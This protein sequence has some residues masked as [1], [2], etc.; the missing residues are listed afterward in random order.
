M[1]Y[2]DAIKKAAEVKPVA[3]KPA[4]EPVSKKAA[5]PSPVAPV[6]APKVEKKKA[7]KKA[8]VEEEAAPKVVEEPVSLPLDIGVAASPWTAMARKPATAKPAPVPEKVEK[9]KAESEDRTAEKTEKVE[10]GAV[11]SKTDDS[12][13]KA[14]KPRREAGERS[15]KKTEKK[16]DKKTEEKPAAVEPVV[17]EVSKPLEIATVAAAGAWGKATIVSVIAAKKAEVVVAPTPAPKKSRKGAAQKE[18][19]PVAATEVAPT[20]KAAPVVEESAP[21]AA[22]TPIEETKSSEI[23][24]D[25]SLEIEGATEVVEIDVEARALPQ[26]PLSEADAPIAVL[27]PLHKDGDARAETPVAP[28]VPVAVSPVKL[29]TEQDQQLQKGTTVSLPVG[30]QKFV[31]PAGTFTFIGTLPAEPVAAPVEPVRAAPVRAA[32]APVSST[33]AHH[34]TAAPHY[35]THNNTMNTYHNN[36]V[37]AN[38][39]NNAPQHQPAGANAGGGYQRNGTMYFDAEPRPYNNSSYNSNT[40]TPS[41]YQGHN[42]VS[43]IGRGGY[44]GGYHSDVPRPNYEGGGGR[45]GG[46]EGRGGYTPVYRGGGGVPRYENSGY[47]PPV[48]NNYSAPVSHHNSHHDVGHHPHQYS[49]APAGGYGGSRYNNMAPPAHSNAYRGGGTSYP[50]PSSNSYT[51]GMGRGRGNS[52]PSAITSPGLFTGQQYGNQGQDYHHQSQQYGGHHQQQRAPQYSS[53]PPGQG[54]NQGY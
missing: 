23:P 20:E 8:V 50:Q 41:A 44:R 15:G 46:Y 39:Y 48:Q 25:A 11:S 1:S 45:G 3:P 26:T 32:A 47:Y 33:P 27:E 37:P 5:A 30:H 42:N 19:A 24:D 22:A 40:H 29:S 53:A 16:A 51:R 14:S 4:A 7:E 34:Q 49:N 6:A 54:Y 52:E 35:N 13:V 38:Q 31:Q 12:E 28:I 21:V 2:A 43:S 17:P 9:K 36:G 10:K 18:S